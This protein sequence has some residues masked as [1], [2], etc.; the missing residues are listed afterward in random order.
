MIR[1]RRRLTKAEFVQL[2]NKP[3]VIN[4]NESIVTKS[5]ENTTSYGMTLPDAQTRNVQGQEAS[6]NMLHAR[7]R[8]LYVPRILGPEF[9]VEA[10]TENLWAWCDSNEDSWSLR[11]FN[12]IQNLI[13]FGYEI[14]IDH[15]HFRIQNHIKN[16]AV[17]Y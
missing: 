2:H 14:H 4:H 3:G 10:A 7:E 1:K 16:D 12:F 11:R 17:S 6:K 8:K 15:I 9:K 13:H 5:D